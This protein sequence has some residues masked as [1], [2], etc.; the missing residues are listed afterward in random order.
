MNDNCTIEICLSGNWQ[1]ATELSL[2]GDPLHGHERT[3]VH[4][5]A[6]N[7]EDEE[8]LRSEMKRL[9]SLLPNIPQWLRDAGIGTPILERC[10]ERCRRVME[11]LAEK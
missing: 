11:D 8:S 3:P 1:V 10:E 4:F 9:L 2:K 7:H 6:T 5:L